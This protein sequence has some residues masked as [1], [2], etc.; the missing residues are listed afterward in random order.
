[1]N[2][3]EQI[4]LALVKSTPFE[5]L[6]AKINAD[7][8]IR[9]RHIKMLE[10]IM[11]AYS[12]IMCVLESSSRLITADDVRVINGFIVDVID[13]KN[14]KTRSQKEK[15]EFWIEDY[16]AEQYI[17]TKCSYYRDSGGEHRRV[18]YDVLLG[19]SSYWQNFREQN[20]ESKKLLTLYRLQE[21]LWDGGAPQSFR[22]DK[23]PDF[24]KNYPWV[25][26]PNVA[27]IHKELIGLENL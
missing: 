19:K 16:Y 24:V 22:Y 6:A 7:N 10:D 26:P 4:E 25:F 13:Q 23:L 8:E 12:Y 14:K 18:H 5:K 27:E 2:Q 11:I 20:P 1:M 3:Q 17:W 21:E 9:D 15:D